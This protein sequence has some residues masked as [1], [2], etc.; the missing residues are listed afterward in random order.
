MVPSTSSPTASLAPSVPGLGRIKS[1]VHMENQYDTSC[2]PTN[3]R[4]FERKGDVQSNASYR[5]LD[6]VIFFTRFDD[7]GRRVGSGVGRESDVGDLGGRVWIPSGARE[8]HA[9]E[10]EDVEFEVP[11]G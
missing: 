5:V 2:A 9:L 3:L 7:P 6:Q 8:R 1:L 4:V 11:G 10:I